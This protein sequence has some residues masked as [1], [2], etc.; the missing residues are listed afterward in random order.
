MHYM[1]TRKMAIGEQPPAGVA[2]FFDVELLTICKQKI[3]HG[4]FGMF[5]SSIGSEGDIF[6]C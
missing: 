5:Y 6:D 3:K 1:D 2:R 4:S